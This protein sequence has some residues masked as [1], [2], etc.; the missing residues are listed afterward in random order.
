MPES[1]AALLNVLCME[2]SRVQNGVRDERVNGDI[3]KLEGA[4][5]KM[6]RL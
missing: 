6:A 5:A 2:L 3:A 4:D 1:L